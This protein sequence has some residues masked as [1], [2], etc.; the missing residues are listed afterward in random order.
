MTRTVVEVAPRGGD[1]S[2]VL[3]GD[4]VVP[5]LVRRR[6]RHVEVALVAGRAMLL[7]RDEVEIDVRLGAG[8][9]LRLVDIGGLVVY[10]RPDEADAA[11]RWHACLD[12]AADAR[13]TWEGLPTVVTA[14]G[15]LLRS[16]AVRLASGSSVVLRETLVL[17]R[18]GEAGGDLRSDTDAADEGG[19]L[20]RET[21]EVRG[22]R[23]EA[24]V[25]GRY[26][27]MDSIV[28]LGERLGPVDDDA[29]TRL[30]L[31][32]GGTVVRDLCEAAHESRL[33]PVW[34]AVARGGGAPEG[35][36]VAA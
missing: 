15:R 6:G 27:V 18:T 26:R 33:G 10:G 32:R 22:T 19:P 14:H 4:L 2:C 35:G 11:S 13:L 9:T 12:L 30:D 1:V 29:V 25:L 28:A 23:P 3:A 8:C 20:L 5:R 31:A 21:L 7:P 16:T 17:G 34:A 36:R 24:G